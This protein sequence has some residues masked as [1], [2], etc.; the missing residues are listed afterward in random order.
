MEGDNGEPTYSIWWFVAAFVLIGAIG[1]AF[2]LRVGS[3]S[4]TI[5]IS[6]PST[7][8]GSTESTTSST[9][10]TP[11]TTTSTGPIATEGPGGQP[12]VTLPDG[13]TQ[14][15]TEGGTTSYA[16]AVPE[17]AELGSEA[18][19]APVQVQVAEDGVT[20]RL[21][22]LCG[23]TADDLPAQIL[24]TEGDSTVTFAVIS[25]GPRNGAPCP[26]D[27]VPLEL[28]I[29]LPSPLGDRAVVVVPAGTSVPSL[30]EG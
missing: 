22:I 18:S 5:D 4:P 9:V 6:P 17:G 10:A 15:L 27:A 23:P 21:R 3:D 7:L 1:L 28:T 24:V 12:V 25:V 8:P 26:D 29:P 14:V 20:A 19:V 16:L 13:V 30:G 11:S 2:V